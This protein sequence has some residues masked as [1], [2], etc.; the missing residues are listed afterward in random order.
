MTFLASILIIAT[1][2]GDLDYI[3][4]LF[5]ASGANTQAGL[6]TVNTNQ[7]NTFQQVVI[8]LFTMISNPITIH[9]SV[10]WLRIYW[11]EKHFE[12][13]TRQAR[14]R[15]ATLSKSRNQPTPDSN[16]VERG[17]AGRHITVMPN[18][19]SRITNDGIVLDKQQGEDSQD[20]PGSSG[21]NMPNS[22]AFEHGTAGN[23]RSQSDPDVPRSSF[24]ALGVPSDDLDAGSRQSKSSAIDIQHHGDEEVLRIPNPRDADR[25]MKPQ[26]LHEGQP[27]EADDEEGDD[28]RP[29]HRRF[30]KLAQRSPQDASVVSANNRRQRQ[31]TI[32]IAEPPRPPGRSARSNNLQV[33]SKSST[34][35]LGGIAEEA[36]ASAPV[37]G[38]FK[39]PRLGLFGRD[40]K[41]EQ[42]D[43]D[44]GNVA[45][46]RNSR[47]RSSTFEVIRRALT[48]ERA[49]EAPYLSWT[50]TLGRNSQFLGLT[51][52]QR[53]ELG[54][55]EYRSLRTL[56]LILFIYFWFFWIIAVVCFLPWILDNANNQYGQAV[57]DADQGLTWWGFFTANSAFLDLGFTLTPDSMAQFATSQYILMIMAFFI[58]VGNTGFP[59]MLRGLIWLTARIVPRQSP[60]WH[61]LRFLLDHPRRCFT[62]LFPS[63]A[64]WWL[65]WI[66][67]GLNALDLIFFIVLDVSRPKIVVF[68][69]D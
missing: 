28:D 67:I 10:V 45:N 12:D 36:D 53:E 14:L 21:I 64:T 63:A 6:N 60:L 19:G 18:T 15:R 17:V 25:G 11:F 40:S 62:L 41:E 46:R 32:T 29:S 7:L 56:A 20:S 49:E 55:I 57:T 37:S 8:F 16:Q 42:V 27:E 69:L 5:F 61:E 26:E 59:V 3:D 35:P 34:K 51:L 24:S 31:A 33:A 4:A 30:G 38:R 54:G 52:E 43:E 47:R 58:I 13:L 66:L 1:A 23:Q 68:C 22:D 44:D 48:G 65:F 9:S 50:P 39:F 2:G